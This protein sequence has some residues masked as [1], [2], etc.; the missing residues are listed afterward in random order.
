MVEFTFTLPD[1]RPAKLVR[2]VISGSSRIS[3]D[4]V[5][6]A[7]T[8][9]PDRPFVVQLSDRKTATVIVQGRGFDYVPRVLVDGNEIQIAPKL[10]LLEYLVAALPVLLI[11]LGGLIGGVIGFGAMA[12]NQWILRRPWPMLGRLGAVLGVSAASFVL[13]VAVVLLVQAILP[14]S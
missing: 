8:N 6:V 3:V 1:G 12:L 5:D 10:S 11:V 9:A 2:S 13:M 14:R 4:G 7:R